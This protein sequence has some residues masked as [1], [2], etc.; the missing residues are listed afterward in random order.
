MNK[1]LIGITG[2]KNSGRYTWSFLMGGL[3]SALIKEPTLS[4]EDLNLI[5]DDM[6]SYMK[7]HAFKDMSLNDSKKTS[8][9]LEDTISIY[10]HKFIDVVIDEV[11]MFLSCSSNQLKEKEK[12]IV[13][14]YDF[15]LI[16]VLDGDNEYFES[17]SFESWE[18]YEPNKVNEKFLRYM[19]IS[20]FLTLYTINMKKQFGNDIWIKI[21]ERSNAKEKSIQKQF[22]YME[23]LHIEIWNDIRQQNELNYIKNNNGITLFLNRPKNVID[24]V[25][26]T[27]VL[28][29]DCDIFVETT[30]K[31][32]TEVR[33]K[34]ILT[35]KE[36]WKKMCQKQH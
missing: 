13:D 31:N 11:S 2:H 33:N 19:S 24:E 16:E 3:L 5:Y 28:P 6:L 15:S 8:K 10:Q 1:I 36:I 4:N 27:N 21:L 18:D 25:Y 22:G 35:T 26:K 7:S 32:L 34:V 9:S 14:M 29:E 12:Y 20:N 17:L 23:D 30:T